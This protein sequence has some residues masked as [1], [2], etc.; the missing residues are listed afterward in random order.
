MLLQP[1]QNMPYC[2]YDKNNNFKHSCYLLKSF[3]DGAYFCY[4][5][6]L[7]R[8]S[9]YS[10]FLWVVPTNTGIFLRGLLNY[11]E[12]AELSK[13]FQYPERNFGGNHAFFRDK[14]ASILDKSSYISLYF[15]VF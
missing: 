4:C 3:K 9:R 5:T 10:G 7:L 8:I 12:K 2:R 15:T 13:C 6:Y 14:E 11:A 1:K